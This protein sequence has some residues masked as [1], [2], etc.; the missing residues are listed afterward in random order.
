MFQRFEK[1]GLLSET[2][3]R[4][5]RDMI[6]SHG[7]SRDRYLWL[8]LGSARND[9]DGFFDCSIEGLK[10]FLGREPTQDA[11]LIHIGVKSTS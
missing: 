5:Y 9:F 8:L 7:G 3:G 10:A 2:L 6:L 4:E 1:E 11:F